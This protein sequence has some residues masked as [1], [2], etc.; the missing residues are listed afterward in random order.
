MTFKQ[1]FLSIA[2]SLVCVLLIDLLFLHFLFPQKRKLWIERTNHK[3]QQSLLAHPPVSDADILSPSSGP[4]TSSDFKTAAQKCLGQGPW[5]DYRQLPQD[6]EKVFGVQS[7]V[8]DIENFDLTTAEGQKRRIHISGNSENNPEVRYYSISADG[9]QTPL[10]IKAEIR[11]QEPRAQV[12][13]LKKSSQVVL[14]QLKQRWLLGNGAS[15]LFTLENDE[16]KDFQIFGSA[17]T[18]TCLQNACQ[19]L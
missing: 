7:K 4:I 14:H 10:A 2:I 13:E 9:E 16:L 6:L 12:E 11:S 5:Q 1:I 17:R 15:F 18:L 19:C 8:I 3:V